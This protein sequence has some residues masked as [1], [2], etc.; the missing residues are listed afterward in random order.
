VRAGGAQERI[1]VTAQPRFDFYSHPSA[2]PSEAALG[3]D[4]YS[5]LFL[6]YAVAPTIQG[7]D[8]A[9]LR[10]ARCICRP[11]ER[12]MSSRDAR[13]AQSATALARRGRGWA[14]IAR[15]VWEQRSG[16][17]RGGGVSGVASSSGQRV[18]VERRPRQIG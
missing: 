5:V 16:V 9:H 8:G 3:D 7:K 14:R 4:G 13:P 10:G 15:R 2:W 6:S 17:D 12:C 11:S 1:V 18:S